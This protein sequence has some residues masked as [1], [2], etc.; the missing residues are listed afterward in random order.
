[1][2]GGRPS[3]PFRI[4]IQ[5]PINRQDLENFVKS[6]WPQYQVMKFQFLHDDI[7]LLGPS[8]ML[9]DGATVKI[10][11]LCKGFSDFIGNKSRA[12]EYAMTES[13][14]VD[15]GIFRESTLTSELEINSIVQELQRKK[16]VF[17]MFQASEYTMREFISPLLVSAL[18]TLMSTVEV[19]MLAEKNVTGSLGNGPVDYTLIYKDFN[20]CVVEAKKDAIEE[21]ISQ[22]IAQLVASR[23]EYCYQSKRSIDEIVDLPSSGIVSTGKEWIFIRYIKEHNG[24]KV[25]RSNVQ[26]IHLD[27][28]QPANVVKVWKR[29]IGVIEFEKN[30]ID[31]LPVLKRSR[32][33]DATKELETIG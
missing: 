33:E 8:F 22:N 1:M 21:G 12:L 31:D 2:T 24:W 3:K 16:N 27:D 19:K 18:C 11:N 30:A 9:P 15:D 25:Y 23:E 4:R 20:I 28:I 5:S 29:I 10:Q 6:Q 17:D 26:Y 7:L 13:I 32:H 14:A